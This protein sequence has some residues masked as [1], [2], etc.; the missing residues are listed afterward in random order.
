M[1]VATGVPGFDELV[2][3]GLL[4]DRLYIVS[5]PPGS[6]KTTFASQFVTKGAIDGQ[7]S[8]FL[9]LHETRDE[10][11]EDMGNYEFG[12]D[13]AVGS[14][15]VKFLNVFESEAKRLLAPSSRSGGDFPDNVENM[16]N[17]IVSFI[18]NKEIDRLVIDSAMLLEYYFS[19]DLDDFIKFLTALK[20]ADATALVISEM[21]DPTSYSDEHY[22]AHGVFFM[23]NYLEE[24]GMQRGVQ[25]IKMRGTKIDSNIHAARFS[26]RG[27]RVDPDAI[28]GD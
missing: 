26:E 17:Q 22:L 12:F 2:D 3:G 14:G 9:S 25:I 5:G 11:V 28:I 15:R 10:L 16:T 8:L 23:H 4:T 6:G 1:R 27:L 19:D 7:T 20:R 24:G 21:T 13:K 18:E